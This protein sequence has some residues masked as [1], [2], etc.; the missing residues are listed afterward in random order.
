MSY[1]AREKESSTDNR[2]Y[3][4]AVNPRGGTKSQA[5]AER[6]D[7]DKDDAGIVRGFVDVI[8]INKG[9][10]SIDLEDKHAVC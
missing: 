7:K 4:R 5:V 8:R 1:S 10:H 6:V 9:K 3:L 2:S